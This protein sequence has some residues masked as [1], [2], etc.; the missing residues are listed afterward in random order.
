MASDKTEH[1]LPSSRF[2]KC[3]GKMKMP[4]VFKDSKGGKR[5]PFVFGNLSEETACVGL[6]RVIFVGNTAKEDKYRQNLHEFYSRT[7]RIFIIWIFGDK[8][9]CAPVQKLR[10]SYLFTTH[11]KEKVCLV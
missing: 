6:W 2:A 3:L 10:Q 5:T 4:F 1:P 7:C 8:N 11:V 9:E